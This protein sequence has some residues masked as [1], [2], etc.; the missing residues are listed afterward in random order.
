MNSFNGIKLGESVKDITTGNTGR[1]VEFIPFPDGMVIS[2][3]DDTTGNTYGA[4][5]HNCEFVS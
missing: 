3:T 2:F 4:Y 1:I 5:L